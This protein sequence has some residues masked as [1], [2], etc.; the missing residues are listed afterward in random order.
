MQ[1]HEL[2]NYNGA[3]D[4][5]AFTVIDNG[6]DTGKISVPDLLE[7]VNNDIDALDTRIDNLISSVTVDSEVIDARIGVN[8]NVYPTLGKAIRGQIEGIDEIL[9]TDIVSYGAVMTPSDSIQGAY[10]LDTGKYVNTVGTQYWVKQ[11]PVYKGLTYNFYGTV[12]LQVTA[13]LIAF[14]TDDTLENNQMLT[15]VIKTCGSTAISVDEDFTPTV[16]GFIYIAS[17]TGR[18]E[19]QVTQK[20]KYDSA[21]LD[22]IETV[23]A[24]LGNSTVL[25]EIETGNEVMPGFYLS[26]TGVITAISDS[27]NFRIYYI[28]V[29]DGETVRLTYDN[30]TLL[31]NYAAVIF[32]TSMP[33]A[34]VSGAILASGGTTAQDL[35]VSYTANA[36]GYLVVANGRVSLDFHF[37]RNVSVLSNVV[38]KNIKIQLFGD[39]ITDNLYG[40]FKTWA[41]LIQSYMLGYNVTVYNDAVGGSGIRGHGKS[42]GTTQSHQ[43]DTYNYVW[44]LVTDGQT[45]QTDADAIVILS[46]TNDWA[47]A[48]PLGDMSSA[49]YSTVYGALKQIVEYIS[50]NTEAI[51]FVCT[52]PQRYNTADQSRPT[53]EY[54]EPLNADGISLADY[55][56]PF[57]KVPAFYGMPVIPLNTAL[58]WNRLNVADFTTDGLHPNVKGDNR[59]AEF[60]CAEIKKH[61]G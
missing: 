35:D 30:Y 56:E 54:G 7:D 36:D 55:C 12:S 51:L 25:T 39:S 37:Y 9:E 45:L 20:T 23:T 60:I 16:N 8:G 46:G 40:D 6:Q 61:L 17:V 49:T 34:G 27:V 38:N 41:N 22:D 19:L 52:I 29:S 26:N 2:N 10:F 42:S 21:R 5:N 15:S 14:D 4:E 53:N 13:G 44:D 18:G 43:D 59:L 3:L 32:T 1:I 28:P 33:A 47:A 11:Y 57:E 58:G 31:G 48:S 24:G 50:N